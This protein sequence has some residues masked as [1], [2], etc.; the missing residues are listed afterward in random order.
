MRIS[1]PGAR[2]FRMRRAKWSLGRLCAACLLPL[3]FF[4]P[5]IRAQEKPSEYDVKAAY[6]FTFGKFVTWP[7]AVK[8]RAT[9]PFTICILGQDPFKGAL[10]AIVSQ[11]RI[12]G[13]PAATQRLSKLDPDTIARCRVIFISSSEEKQ[14]EQILASLGR[15]QILTVSDIAGFSRRGGMIEFVLDQDKVRFTVNLAAARSAGL[16]LSSELLKV[17]LTVREDGRHGE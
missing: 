7:P 9:E 2:R 11:G 3:L 13:L 1:L 4:T 17:A 10:D 5:S 15:A 16:V 12:A 14:L 8:E 6:L